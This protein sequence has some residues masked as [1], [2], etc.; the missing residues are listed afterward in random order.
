MHEGTQTG[1]SSVT[2]YYR[3]VAASAA[4]MW[5]RSGGRRLGGK[6]GAPGWGRPPPV[7]TLEGESRRRA[8]SSVHGAGPVVLVGHSYGGAV[9]TEAGQPSPRREVPRQRNDSHGPG[10]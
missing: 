10:S 9:V 3:A 2:L 4:I 8:R 7:L 5:C 6:G 1:R